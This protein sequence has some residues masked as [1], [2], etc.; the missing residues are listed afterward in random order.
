M[1]GLIVV[2]IPESGCLRT[3]HRGRVPRSG[4]FLVLLGSSI[5]VGTFRDLCRSSLV[6]GTFWAP[7]GF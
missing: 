3:V 5:C 7:I 6:V 2:V 4:T 1:G